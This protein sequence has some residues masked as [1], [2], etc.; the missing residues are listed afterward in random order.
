VEWWWLKKYGGIK[1]VALVETMPTH[2]Y[3]VLTLALAKGLEEKGRVKIL[4]S[5]PSID[6]LFAKMP[7]ELKARLPHSV[8]AT[9]LHF[10]KSLAKLMFE[11]ITETEKDG[12]ERCFLLY[13]TSIFFVKSEVFKGTEKEVRFPVATGAFMQFHTHP[14]GVPPFPSSDDIGFILRRKVK[15][16]A[17]G[18]PGEGVYFYWKGGVVYHLKEPEPIVLLEEPRHYRLL[19]RKPEEFGF[20]FVEVLES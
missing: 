6:E 8:K 14:K 10:P 13:K 15:Y 19:L 7:P 1:G 18:S 9:V 3:E 11:L 12:L 5:A 2:E 20:E 4:M 16:L 17:I